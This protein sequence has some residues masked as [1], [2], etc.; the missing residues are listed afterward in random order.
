MGIEWWPCASTEH[1]ADR[2]KIE[3]RIAELEKQLADHAK[4]K[5]G[6]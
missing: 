3:A 4:Q 1:R 6:G 2:Q 5:S